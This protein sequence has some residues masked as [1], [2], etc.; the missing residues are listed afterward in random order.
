MVA[1]RLVVSPVFLLSPT[2]SGST[3]LRCLLNAHPQIHAPHEL[4]VADLGVTV[5]TPYARMGLD[6]AGLGLREVE[7]LLW[8]RLLHRELARSGKQVLV[9]KVPSNVLIFDRLAQ[10]WPAARFLFLVRHPANI[11]ASALEAGPDRGP[12]EL[13]SQVL[14]YLV[15]LEEARAALAGPTV[16]YEDLT[17]DPAR[18]TRELCEF[19]DVEWAAAMLDY[20]AVEQ[21][22]FLYGIGI[23]D[24]SEN[25]RAGRVLPGRPLPPP[26]EVPGFLMPFCDAWGYL[27]LPAP[28][29][30]PTA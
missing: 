24:W 13:T 20:G 27:E 10:A 23:G 18:V 3:L 21:G 11:L 1:D 29:A 9:D 28:D 14:R 7:H 4:H 25:I 30:G 26:E 8:D 5:G 2:R 15:R 16:R 12:G 19:L 22:P 17:A 6:V